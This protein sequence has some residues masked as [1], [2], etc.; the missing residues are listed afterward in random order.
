MARK[1]PRIIPCVC[2]TH[3]PIP[4]VSNDYGMP[5]LLPKSHGNGKTSWS[6]ACPMCGRGSL[7]TI[8]E[9]SAYKAIIHWNKI[10]EKCYLVAGRSIEYE[11]DWNEDD[12]D[13][14]AECNKWVRDLPAGRFVIDAEKSSAK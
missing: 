9:S 11:K 1:I 5:I 10:M 12:P 7:L 13:G 6:I 8:E 4:I 3:T 14:R 2:T